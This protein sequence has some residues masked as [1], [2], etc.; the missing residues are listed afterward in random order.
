MSKDF[1]LHYLSL[2]R[3]LGDDVIQDTSGAVMANAGDTTNP[4]TVKSAVSGKTA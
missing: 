4:T 1:F 3:D 2:I